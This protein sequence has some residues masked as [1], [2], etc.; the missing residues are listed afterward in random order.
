M[1][2]TADQTTSVPEPLASDAPDE[3]T[4]STSAPAREPVR[5]RGL[6]AQFNKPDHGVY[7]DALCRAIETEPA[8][9]N[10]ALTGAYGTGKSSILGKV[11]DT[12]RE[13]VL[14]VA[15]ST[16][17][18]KEDGD[19]AEADGRAAAWSETNRI[20]KEIVKQLLYRDDPSRTRGSRFRRISGFHKKHEI[21]GALA[22]TGLMLVLLFL[23][24]RGRLLVDVAP[25]NPLLTAL[26]Y[27]AV[28]IIV[29]VA[30]VWL[31]WATHSR[32]FLEKLS[33]G[34]ATVSLSAH[35]ISYF[36]QYMDEIVYYF[37]HSGRDIVIFE[38]LDRFDNAQIFETL[39]ALNTLLNSSEQVKSRKRRIPRGTPKP[40]GPA[41]DVKFIYALRDSVFEKLA[42]DELAG[43]EV[44]R[45]NRTKFFDLVIP[46]VP[47]I[48]HRNAR[49]LMSE[50][51]EGTGVTAS[52]IGLAAK[53]VADQ[54][55]II[56][57]RNEYDV[58][59]NRLL[60]TP[61]QIG[62]LDPDRLFAMILYKNVH[63]A[64]FENIRLGTSD[65]DK[66]HRGW[67]ELVEHCIDE[68]AAKIRE[69][70]NRLALQDGTRVAERSKQLGARLQALATLVIPS[71]YDRSAQVVV[72]TRTFLRP[73]FGNPELWRAVA[74]GSD[75]VVLSGPPLGSSWQMQVTQ[76]RTLLGDEL[77][78]DRWQREGRAELARD[79]L[80]AT[81]NQG[82]LRHHSWQALHARPEFKISLAEESEPES[83]SQL[84]ARL[85][86]SALARDLV[87]AG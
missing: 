45:A 30:I 85:L 2:S 51:M 46:V 70:E 15:L 6:G 42:D 50:Q 14:E 64:D 40:A 1:S 36:D 8:M 66:L 37:E 24:G 60:G 81:K 5:L 75:P 21:A 55:L 26:A 63:M 76:L 32:V 31:R 20:Q 25:G 13:R 61:N 27:L 18:A 68:Q 28:L 11:A 22:A 10:I 54:R 73:E 47:F 86:R 43:E 35:S 49:D 9:R 7:F 77:D 12:Y 23:S 83:F 29:S 71:G 53:H 34:P 16:I 82:F 44:K 41:P 38:D 79:Q 80:T 48:T 74:V 62:G 72:G 17:G 67:Q 39:R 33:A 3:R 56:N 65:L 58:F 69:L 59:A 52:L 84:T 78:V 57:M 19:E 87:A 4:D